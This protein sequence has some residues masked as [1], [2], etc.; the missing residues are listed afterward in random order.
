MIR[1]V[2]V[3]RWKRDSVACAVVLW[4]AFW[5]WTGHATTKVYNISNGGRVRAF[6]QLV[7][8]M[9][10]WNTIWR[11][12]YNPEILTKNSQRHLGLGLRFEGRL[13]IV[14]SWRISEVGTRDIILL[15]EC[16]ETLGSRLC[17]PPSLLQKSKCL[18]STKCVFGWGFL[19]FPSWLLAF[20]VQRLAFSFQLELELEVQLSGILGYFLVRINS[21]F[22]GAVK[23]TFRNFVQSQMVA[24]QRADTYAARS[25]SLT[26]QP[27]EKCPC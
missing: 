8:Y 9:Q 1:C 2:N 11:Y 24:P 12:R 19:Y 16:L 17:L 25:S 5:A 22:A 14:S 23:F 21:D 10:H 26:G 7:L 3:H 15:V 4:A 27:K 13:R 6:L 18:R 20:S